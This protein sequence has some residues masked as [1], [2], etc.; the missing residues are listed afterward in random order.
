M[1]QE[2]ILENFNK[3]KA[4]LATAQKEENYSKLAELGPKLAELKTKI[5]AE[6]KTQA[7]NE[8]KKTKDDLAKSVNNAK[9]KEA[10]VTA[11]QAALETLGVKKATTGT[12]AAPTK[13]K[14]SATTET[15][16]ARVYQAIMDLQAKGPKTEI[17][18]GKIGEA[19]NITDNDSK[20]YKHLQIA[21]KDLVAF[22][23]LKQAGQKAG[24][25]YFVD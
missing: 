3:L 16:K 6:A 25:Y 2:N 7:E 8:F 19:L 24:T 5:E 9:T 11:L 15:I 12:G 1:S 17:K 18:V 21:L 13:T 14:P 22:E 23:R 4:E 10:L 20:E